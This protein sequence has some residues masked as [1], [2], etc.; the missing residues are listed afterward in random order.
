MKIGDIISSRYVVQEHI[1]RGGMQDV[2]LAYDKLLGVEVA[3]KPLKLD[4]RTSAS[5]RVRKLRQG[6]IIITSPKLWTILRRMN[7]CF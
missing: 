7:G 4:S 2:Y 6:S 5:S 3:S 1:G